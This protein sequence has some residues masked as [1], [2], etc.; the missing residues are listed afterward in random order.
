MCEICCKGNDNLKMHNL[1]KMALHDLNIT[2]RKE[3]NVSS[4]HVIS[5]LCDFK[6]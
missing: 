4:S 6:M 1:K 3:T 5:K 2:L